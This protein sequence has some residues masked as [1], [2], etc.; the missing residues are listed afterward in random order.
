MLKFLG[1]RTVYVRVYE[2]RFIIRVVGEAQNPITLTPQ[3]PFSTERLIVANFS[4][5]A[6]TL[7]RGLKEVLPK[8]T[9][10]R[11]IVVI[12]QMEHLDEPLTEVEVR[13]FHELGEAAGARLVF[14]LAGRD[15]EL[16]DDEIKTVVN[17]GA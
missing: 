3:E 13:A 8:W 9:L 1:D 11:P 5:A 6:E 4:S 15:F 7:A 14:T 10:V 2:N 16:S 12:H 17:G